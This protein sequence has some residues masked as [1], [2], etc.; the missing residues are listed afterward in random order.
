MFIPSRGMFSR[1]LELID[2]LTVEFSVSRS[3]A[4]SATTLTVVDVFSD[5]QLRIGG[6]DLVDLHHETVP[7][8]RSRSQAP[9]R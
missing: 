1:V 6:Y 3:N 9:L 5:L 8:M 2:V 7:P 4:W